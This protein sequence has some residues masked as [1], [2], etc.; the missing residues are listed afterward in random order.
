MIRRAALPM[1][2]ALAAPAAAQTG[3]ADPTSFAG[4]ADIT[5]Q[6]E[7]LGKAMRPGQGF[8]WQPLVRSGVQVAA[9]EIWRSPGRPAVHPEEA[10]YATVIAGAGTLV[11]GGSLAEPK[12]VKP[13]LTEGSRIVGGTTR[14]LAPGD[15][16]LIPAGTPHWFGITGDRLVLLGTK[17]AV[18]R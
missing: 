2:A 7:A 11:S 3:A 5:A 13:G 1:L 16:M 17:I 6:V 8:A 14:R 9:I 15:V 12:V 18:P 4:T 10:E